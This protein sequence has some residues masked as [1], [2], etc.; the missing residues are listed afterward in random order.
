MS[1]TLEG[2]ILEELK[3]QPGQKARSI[4]SKL[5]VEKKAVN[6]LLYGKLRGECFQ[7]DKYEWYLKKEKISS[8][9]KEED[10]P[11]N[12]TP[13]ARLCR[14]YLACLG[15][16]DQNGVSV[17]ASSTF[18]DLDYCELDSLPLQSNDSLY[19]AP[20][21]NN[22]LG[23]LR[24]DKSKLSLYFGYPTTLKKVVSNKG[25]EGFFVE[26]VFLF[27]VEL[28]E[29]YASEPRLSQSFPI[30]NPAVLKRFSNADRDSLMYEIGA[31]E[32]ELGLTSEEELPEL[33]DLVLRLHEKRPEWPWLEQINPEEISQD[34]QLSEA[35]KEGIYN[36]GVLVLSNRTPYTQGLESELK[37]L[38]GI[39]EDE[40]KETA[41]GKWINGE[42]NSGEEGEKNPLIDVLPVNLEQSLAI[43][44]AMTEP[45]TVI[46]G[47]PGTGKSQV[48]TNLLINAAWQGKKVLFASKNN[49]AVDVVEERVNSLGSRPVLLRMGA[50][51]YQGCLANYL[52]EMM[53]ASVSDE[54]K[55]EFLWTQ[56]NQE[57]FNL[58][59]QKLELQK[60]EVVQLRNRVDEIEQEVEHFRKSFQPATF[61][62]IR[63]LDIKDFSMKV[64]SFVKAAKRC[65][66]Q[67]QGFITRIFWGSIS[68]KRFE[69]LSAVRDDLN[70]F[71]LPE[72][73]APP[74]GNPD[75]ENLEEWIRRGLSLESLIPSVAKVQE[76][77]D[78]LAE[79]QKVKS[80]EETDRQI[81]EIKKSS[82]ENM[83]KLWESWV[84]LQ[85]TRISAED[86][87]MLQKYSAL[88]KM[89]IESG[90]ER[91]ST[92]VSREYKKLFE[93]TA[94]L[95][96]CWAVTSLSAKGRIPFQS[97]YFDLVV[98]DEASQCDIASVLPLLFRA[99]RVAIIG[100][101]QQLSHITA[102]QKNQDSLL[103]EKFDLVSEYV[104]WSYSANSLF[105]LAAGFVYKGNLVN[106]LD[107]HRSHEQI[108]GFSNH[109]FYE[110]R[111]RIAT[112]YKN[113]VRPPFDGP[114]VRWI[115]V[116]G[117][118][119]RPGGK[120]AVNDEEAKEVV[121]LL[122]NIVLEKGYKGGVG[123]VSPF[124]AQANLIQELVNNNST[125]S[126]ELLD[127]G[128]LSDTVHRFQGDERDMM[129]FSPVISSGVTAGALGFLKNT[130]KLFNVAITRARGALIVVGD[131]NT[132]VQ[133]GV[134]YLSKFASY[135]ITLEKE[136][137]RKVELCSEKYGPEYPTVA[138]PE[139]VSDWERYFYKILYQ[140]GIHTLPQYQ[141]EKYALDLALID[142]DR[143]L[144]IEVDGERYHRNWT[145]ELCRR[146]QLRN[147]RLFELGWDVL[148]FWVYE[149]RD[150]TNG[151]VERVKQWLNNSN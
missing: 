137:E 65:D 116:Q 101:P 99:K 151:C 100:D 60:E 138:Y 128:F 64:E 44:K 83:V 56:K 39:S 14:Y 30:I 31:L 91:L 70:F 118:M 43:E 1:E 81:V 75:S 141:V 69:N 12:N 61:R 13:L 79:L 149:I 110:G 132:A 135:T 29:R 134:N 92:K 59:L 127:H 21:T 85:P 46:T 142:G 20:G 66:K 95:F 102:L 26:P 54:E 105:D 34:P 90:K 93:K 113:L 7:G 76:Y 50:N 129:I 42:I 114:K 40:Y 131:R 67:D 136:E 4:A 130:P 71:N 63:D 86:R 122:E 140:E 24:R 88:L 47:P 16:D 117:K 22:I 32:E 78:S 112:R 51:E 38:T 37:A 121:R 98:I 115:N 23:R 123:V 27:P 73:L 62:F 15:Q 107:H 8:D 36:R 9:L 139:R 19:T 57:K 33:D 49:K 148:R 82:S 52:S 3:R 55:D 146:D 133:S 87:R 147:Q 58:Q 125:L 119:R 103:L 74:K 18:G 45:L 35:Q 111:L 28:D 144:D 48:V 41:L 89:V 126:K 5:G 143:M 77:F 2:K 84:R 104:H 68:G 11:L 124:R 17:F 6:S 10:L 72:E 120:S 145:G 106:L 25:W 108:I 96:P 53:S 150:D 97:N 80:L 109:L 94:H